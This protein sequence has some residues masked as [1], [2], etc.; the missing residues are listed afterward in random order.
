MAAI[1]QFAAGVAREINNPIQVIRGH[2]KTMGP[3]TP[4]AV[5]TEDLKIILM[6]AFASVA[7]AVEALRLGAYDYLIKPFDPQAGRAVVVRAMGRA[8]ER[9]EGRQ[10]HR[11]TDARPPDVLSC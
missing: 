1:G 2:L 9:C 11:R 7:T 8:G 10:G 6:T 3:G 4:P 5:L